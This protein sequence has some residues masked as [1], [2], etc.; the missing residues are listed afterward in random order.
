MKEYPLTQAE[1]IGL[2]GMSF[3]ATAF[4]SIASWCATTWFDV[5]K[6]IA[7]GTGV[8]DNTVGY[9]QGLETA[10][11]AAAVGFALLGLIFLGLNGVA[12]LNIIRST[13]HS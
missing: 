7:F 13:K 11:G 1:L 8:P 3:A 5:H 6:D 12:L 10:F 4:F 9:Y 2:G